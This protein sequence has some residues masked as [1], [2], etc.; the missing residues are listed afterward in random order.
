MGNIVRSDGFRL[1]ISGVSAASL[2][3]GL[4]FIIRLDGKAESALEKFE[5]VFSE[6]IGLRVDMSKDR[7]VLNEHSA[8]IRE[9]RVMIRDLQNRT[10]STGNNW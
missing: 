7:E 6:V 2:L 8:E 5:K 9:H 4:V 10:K 1:T 3:C